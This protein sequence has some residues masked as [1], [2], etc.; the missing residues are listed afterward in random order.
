MIIHFIAVGQKMPKWVQEGYQEYAKRL[1]KA[2][3]L[4]LVEI[5]MA[6]RGKSG[7]VSQY[8]AEEAKRILA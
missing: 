3:A 8:K 1:P 5:P 2:C 4:K 6:T 7:S